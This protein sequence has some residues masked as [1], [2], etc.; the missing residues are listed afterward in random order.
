MQPLDIIATPPVTTVCP[1][2]RFAKIL[3]TLESRAEGPKSLRY[4]H[5]WSISLV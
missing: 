4:L 3:I 1:E 2:N 5:R